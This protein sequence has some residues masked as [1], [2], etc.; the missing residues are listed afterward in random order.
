MTTPATPA[1]APARPAVA[2]PSAAPSTAAPS[3]AA[4]GGAAGGGAPAAP[5]GAQPAAPAAQPA[6][7]QPSFAR[8]QIE[9]RDER[10]RAKA[11]Q[12]QIDTLKPHETTLAELRDKDPK[13]RFAALEK[14]GLSYQDWTDHLLADAGAPPDATGKLPP[15][16]KQALE[17]LADLKKWKD[18]RVGAETQQQTRDRLERG[19]AEAKTLLAGGGA[20]YELAASLGA[21]GDVVAEYL[22]RAKR[23][24]VD[25][26]EHEIAAH[27]EQQLEQNIPTQ[28][29]AIAKTAKGKAMLQK[30]LQDLSAAPAQN[31][32]QASP[33]AQTGQPNGL[34]NELSAQSG[35]GVDLSKLTDA[36]LRARAI[37]RVRRKPS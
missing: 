4:G 17:E 7:Q 26:D 8:L 3:P 28:L 15:E 23:D 16:V 20:K 11:L 30:A 2:A 5:N 13:K 21:E 27:V 29:A 1:A 12:T 32:A 19:R 34:T 33:R 35:D 24:G 14:L 10:A 31:G 25:P 37:E 9:L 22:A 6:Q 18:E 36:Q